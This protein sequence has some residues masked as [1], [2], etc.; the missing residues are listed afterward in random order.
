[1][2]QQLRKVWQA[3]VLLD[4]KAN[5]AD[6]PEAVAA[7]MP[8]KGSILSDPEWK[9]RSVIKLARNLY[10]D[11]I[12]ACFEIVA[13]ADSRLK[14]SEPGGYSTV[15]TLERMVLELVGVVGRAGTAARKP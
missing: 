7:L 11:Q 1:M 8:E 15:D 5:F 13:Q 2:D 6:V 12:A 9:Q 10:L 4:A 3:R 14:G